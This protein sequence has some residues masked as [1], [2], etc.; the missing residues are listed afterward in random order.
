MKTEIFSDGGSRGNPGDAAIGYVIKTQ[1]NVVFE[2]GSPIG[3]A[4]NNVAEYT[5]AYQAL[6]KA[7]ELGFDE[8]TLYLDSQLVERQI[9]GIYKV[10]NE[11]LAV[12]RTKIL[13]II[14]EFSKV[15]VVHVKRELNRA[16]DKLVNRALDENR[17]IEI[18]NYAQQATSSPNEKKDNEFGFGDENPLIQMDRR[19]KKLLDSDNIMTTKFYVT[20]EKLII[21]IKKEDALKMGAVSDHIFKEM[22]GT[23]VSK[24]VLEIEGE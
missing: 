23:T 14:G 20:E 21:G 17:E 1:E 3:I 8:V 15:K 11:D 13:K 10:K 4:T 19:I 12:L 2:Y 22:N 16:A 18:N 24:L 9:N 5:A 6:S 7:R